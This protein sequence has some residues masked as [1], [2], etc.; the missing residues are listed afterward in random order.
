[1]SHYFWRISIKKSRVIVVHIETEHIRARSIVAISR[2]NGGDGPSK[3]KPGVEHPRAEAEQQHAS[4]GQRRVVEVY[5][6]DGVRHWQAE[7]HGDKGHPE[8]GDPADDKAVASEMKRP[9]DK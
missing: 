7:Q 2:V 9:W 5:P 3:P 6:G 8:D 4:D 1:M